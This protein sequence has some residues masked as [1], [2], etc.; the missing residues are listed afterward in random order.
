MARAT[1][2]AFT[3]ERKIKMLEGWRDLAVE[4]SDL[5]FECERKIVRLKNKLARLQAGIG[6]FRDGSN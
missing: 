4:R 5:W 6:E 1:V 3:I 2:D